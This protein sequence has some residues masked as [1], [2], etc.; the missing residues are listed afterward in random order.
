MLFLNQEILLLLNPLL[1]QKALHA[2]WR[3]QPLPVSTAPAVLIRSEQQQ[4][5]AQLIALKEPW[6]VWVAEL[7]VL[8]EE[9]RSDKRLK[10]T[11]MRADYVQKWLDGILR[12]ANDPEVL[13]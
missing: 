5:Q 9:A 13:C 8:I 2:V 10:G 12:F 11:K 6:P 1:L 7:A 4:R 3:E